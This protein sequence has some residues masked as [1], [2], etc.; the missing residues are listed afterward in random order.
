MSRGPVLRTLRTHHSLMN[1]M[2]TTSSLVLLD[3]ATARLL[4]DSVGRYGQ[5]DPHP[6]ETRV[7]WEYQYRASQTQRAGGLRGA[8]GLS[9]R[10]AS[11]GLGKSAVSA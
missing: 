4:A 3:A 2:E 10:V 6:S 9:G 5:R 8:S 11:G 7:D 1:G